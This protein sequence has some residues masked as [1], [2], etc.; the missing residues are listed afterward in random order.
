LTVF[1]TKVPAATTAQI[2]IFLDAT[3]FQAKFSCTDAMNG[4]A[5]SCVPK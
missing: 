2:E 3:A 4:P 5:S 1:F